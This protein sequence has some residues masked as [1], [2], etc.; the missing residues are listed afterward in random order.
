M[1]R[2]DGSSVSTTK[3]PDGSKEQVE[4]AQDGTVTT[5]M[6]HRDGSTSIT[7]AA[8]NGS[9][10]SKAEVST[11]RMQEAQQKGE[12]VALPM[13][14][15]PVT[16]DR[17]TA[18]AVT[19]DLPAGITARVE[20]PVKD[21]TPGTVAVLVKANGED[22]IIKTT[23][24]TQTGV[25][26]KISDGDTVKIIDN[27]KQFV[28]VPSTHWGADAV[29][30]VASRTLFSGTGGQKFSPDAPMNRG[31]IV[32]VLARLEGVDTASNPVWYEAGRQWAVA[33]GISDGAHL[34]QNLTRE[35][36][37][38]MLYRYAGQPASSGTLSGYTDGDKVSDWAVQAMGW[39]V[40]EGLISGG[41]NHTLDPQGQATRAQVAA[42]LQRFIEADKV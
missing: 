30:F 24:T 18:S 21:V 37:A 22:E 26:V 12:A 40:N 13:P 4:T 27:S 19:V 23:I 38:L 31:M 16:G 3:Q 5:T 25:A 15:V 42:I 20:I 2:P 34:D 17:S 6:E 28:D 29:G 1:T 35:Q 8:G 32:T 33:N 7:V 41:G 39:A 9:L 10:T 14:P 36:L 11:Q